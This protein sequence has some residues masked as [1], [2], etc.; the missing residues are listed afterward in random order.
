M[1]KKEITYTDFNG[2]KRTE[3]FYFNMSMDDIVEMGFSYEEGMEEYLHKIIDTE[4]V[5]EIYYTF[6]KI[7]LD[8]YGEKSEDGRRF[9]KSKELSEAF[10]QTSAFSELLISFIKDS[11]KAAD[12]INALVPNAEIETLSATSNNS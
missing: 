4:D 2:D 5:K 7:V 9:I 8:S 10:S 1:I 3:D 6:K 12:F 11:N